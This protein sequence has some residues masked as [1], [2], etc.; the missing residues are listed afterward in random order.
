MRDP[1]R[2]HPGADMEGFVEEVMAFIGLDDAD[3]ALIR[4]T[5]PIV[6]KHERTLTEALYDHLLKFPATARFFLK[7]NGAPDMQRLERRKHS[8]G[9]WL[10]E[11]AEVSMTHDFVYYLLSV[12][13]SHSHRQYG[14]GGKV[15]PQFMVGAISL[16]QTALARIFQQELED[17]KQAFEAALVWNKLLLVHLNVLLIGYLLPP[18]QTS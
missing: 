15:P 4:H 16:A 18:R 3:I 10:R 6:L 17:P 9:R 2:L 1:Q 14:P 11:T 5:A 8:L 13:L 7:E 12:S